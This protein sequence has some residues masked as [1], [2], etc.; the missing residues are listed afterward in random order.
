VRIAGGAGA[1]RLSFYTNIGFSRQEFKP[2]VFFFTKRPGKWPGKSDSG[3]H[4]AL[5]FL[6]LSPYIS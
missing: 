5:D 3:G 4:I 1:E 2:S 6:P